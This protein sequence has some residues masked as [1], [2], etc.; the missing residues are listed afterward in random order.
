MAVS[1][2]LKRDDAVG[3]TRGG[4]GS[5]WMVVV[6]GKGVLLGN[7]LYS[8][9]SSQFTL[10]ETTLNQI[11]VSRSDGGPPRT[12]PDRLIYDKG[13]GSDP[14]RSCLKERGIELIAPHKVNRV[15]PKTQD[16]RN[17]CRYRRG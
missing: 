12:K 6:D 7:H 11:S 10:V 9:S 5:K 4:K 15:K 14:L 17:L 16:G 2:L 3:K 8:A 13:A 1:H